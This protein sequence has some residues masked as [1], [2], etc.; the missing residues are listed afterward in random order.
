MA[1]NKETFHLNIK[2]AGMMYAENDNLV[3]CIKRYLV[4]CGYM[5]HGMTLN[6]EDEYD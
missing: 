4:H 6:L 5:I 2:L 1:F 3:G